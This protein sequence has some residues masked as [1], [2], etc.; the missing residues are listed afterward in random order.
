M[1]KTPP[2]DEMRA[3]QQEND[4][5]IRQLLALLEGRP[6]IVA[7]TASTAI[8]RILGRELEAARSRGGAPAAM[9]ALVEGDR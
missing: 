7:F 5:L 8:S 9:A 3:L 6:L 1:R 4:A 2:A